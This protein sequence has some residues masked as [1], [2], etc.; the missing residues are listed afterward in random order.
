MCDVDDAA[1]IRISILERRDELYI[2]PLAVAR[3]WVS[4]L[5]S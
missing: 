2:I 5:A 4:T 3:V 1:F